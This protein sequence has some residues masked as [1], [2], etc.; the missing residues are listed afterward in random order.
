MGTDLLSNDFPSVVLP[1]LLPYL[2]QN[3]LYLH[4]KQDTLNL[5]QE[6]AVKNLKH[7]VTGE[8]FLYRTPMTHAVGPKTV[9]NGTP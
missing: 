1:H 6:R 2:N 9:S 4:V 3:P 8:M 5:I 7:I